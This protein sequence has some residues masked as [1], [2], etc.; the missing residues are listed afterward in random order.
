MNKMILCRKDISDKLFNLIIN[1]KGD[2]IVYQD[3]IGKYYN[4]LAFEAIKHGV[5]LSCGG[6][7]KVIAIYDEGKIIYKHE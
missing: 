1:C 3:E 7:I 5:G 4:Q 2:I 6:L